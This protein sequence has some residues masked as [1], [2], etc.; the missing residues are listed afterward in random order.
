[1]LL[2]YTYN[3]YFSKK[4]ILRV[5]R[6]TNRTKPVYKIMKQCITRNKIS[7]YQNFLSKTND[8]KKRFDHE[9]R[10]AQTTQP[11]NNQNTAV[12]QK[13]SVWKNRVQ[14]WE[15]KRG[16][17]RGANARCLAFFPLSASSIARPY[18]HPQW[19]CA[20]TCGDEREATLVCHPCAR[21]ASEF[22]TPYVTLFHQTQQ[23]Q[24]RIQCTA[25]HSIILG[26]WERDE[27][28]IL[29]IRTNYVYIMLDKAFWELSRDWALA[30]A[31]ARGE[32]RTH[33]FFY[34]TQN[35][36][37]IFFKIMATVNG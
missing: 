25:Q 10:V 19:V 3:N 13:R 26:R 12:Y 35:N 31:W 22:P 33:V 6:C 34:A 28:K 21:V 14:Q 15:Y 7:N 29:C 8:N 27:H 5:L 16:T 37:Y 4:F 17:R 32:L 11:T 1:M 9:N 36:L 23:L 18:P 20:H 30:D 2:I 24:P